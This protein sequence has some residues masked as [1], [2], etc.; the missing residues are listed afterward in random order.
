MQP[1]KLKYM[2]TPI[3]RILLIDDDSDD[4]FLMKKA[5]ADAAPTVEMDHVEDCDE[6][7]D[8][9]NKSIPDLIFLDIN[10]RKRNGLECLADIKDHS[11][12]KRISVIMYSSSD[13]PAHVTQAY[14]YGANLY[15]KKPSS[16][17]AM[18]LSLRSILSLDWSRPESITSNQFRKDQFQPFTCT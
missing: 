9:L 1:K 13:Y 17:P 18:V 8:S 16:Y 2:N 7:F 4:A 5:L 3:Q 11:K 15:L 10:M 14:G 6:I 12:Y